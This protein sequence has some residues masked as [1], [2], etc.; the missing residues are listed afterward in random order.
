MR[1]GRLQYEDTQ[2]EERKASRGKSR[3]GR[4]EKSGVEGAE[5]GQRTAKQHRHETAADCEADE[6]PVGYPRAYWPALLPAARVASPC[7]H[8]PSIAWMRDLN[9]RRASSEGDTLS[10]AARSTFRASRACRTTGAS[11]VRNLAY[12]SRSA[13]S[14]ADMADTC[15]QAFKKSLH[16]IVHA[17]GECRTGYNNV[18]STFIRVIGEQ[19]NNTGR[20]AVID[21]SASEVTAKPNPARLC[22]TQRIL[23]HFNGANENMT[24]IMSRNSHFLSG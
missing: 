15:R 19:R 23:H 12:S 1:Q 6:E 16:F 11:A 18:I 9:S 24:A 5:D 2:G 20:I 10:T 13:D 8:S 21:A 3:R 14:S 17:V 7:P 4:S 22:H